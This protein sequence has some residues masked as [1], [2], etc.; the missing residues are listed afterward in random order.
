MKDNINKN[1]TIGV[2]EEVYKDFPKLKGR[3]YVC[4]VVLTNKRLIIYTKGNSISSNRKIT[5]RGMTEVELK[6]INHMEYFLEFVKNSFFVRLLGFVF[7]ISAVILGY[8]IFQDILAAPV[9]P[10]SQYLNYAALG[11]TFIIGTIL[12]FR[13]KKVLSF[14][15]VSGFNL[16]TELKLMPTK[17]NELALQYLASR[18][19]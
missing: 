3:D 9:Y 10:Y 4:Q 6:S 18:F 14:K 2:G 12:M 11:L 17:Y 1:I 19:Y 7:M 8:G 5:K 16:A 15:V 13:V